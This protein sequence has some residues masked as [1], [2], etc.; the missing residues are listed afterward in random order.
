M[1]KFLAVILAATMTLGLVACS[2]PSEE[3]KAQTEAVQTEAD[4]EAETE[5]AEAAEEAA[6]AV[7][8][9]VKQLY[10]DFDSAMEDQIG[11]MPE[12][13]GEIKVGAVVISLTNPF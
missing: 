5:T 3:T 1:K 11:K 7:S 10:A 6:E 8:D 9:T 4:T 13:F 12:D 2:A